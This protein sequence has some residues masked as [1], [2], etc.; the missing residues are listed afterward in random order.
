MVAVDVVLTLNFGYLMSQP[1]FNQISMANDIVG[2]LGRVLLA[3]QR[4]NITCCQDVSK[5]CHIYWSSERFHCIKNLWDIMIVP[6]ISQTLRCY[7]GVMAC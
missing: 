5:V 3:E 4:R 6:G 2:Q 1:K 7:Q